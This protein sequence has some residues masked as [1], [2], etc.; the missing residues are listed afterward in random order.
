MDLWSGGRATRRII[1]G[2]AKSSSKGSPR[3][4]SG[5]GSESSRC[6]KREYSR[7]TR[8]RET[9]RVNALKAEPDSESGTV[10]YLTIPVLPRGG[11]KR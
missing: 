9:N 11:G 4:I 7:F 3:P 8:R 5:P 6:T 10:R 2:K 1:L